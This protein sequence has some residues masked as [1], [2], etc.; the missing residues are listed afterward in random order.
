MKYLAEFES[1]KSGF[2]TTINEQETGT[3]KGFIVVFGSTDNDNLRAGAAEPLGFKENEVITGSIKGIDS[4]LKIGSSKSFENANHPGK[5]VKP[6]YDYLNVTADGKKYSIKERGALKIPFTK[7]TVLEIEGAGNGLLALMRALYFL[8]ISVT[9]NKFDYNVPFDG[10][11]FIK[12]G[13]T[14][15]KGLSL[16]VN[17]KYTGSAVIRIS[18]GYVDIMKKFV[19]ESVDLGEAPKQDNSVEQIITVADTIAD[20]IKAS[21][22]YKMKQQYKSFFSA[23]KGFRDMYDASKDYTWT[24]GSE[25]QERGSF[26]LAVAFQYCIAT[27]SYYYPMD[28]SK[29][30]KIDLEPYAKKIMDGQGSDLTKFDE[31]S[32]RTQIAAMFKQFEPKEL[33]DYP[34]FKDQLPKYWTV[35]TNAVIDRIILTM[36]ST[37]KMA[38]SPDRVG[39]KVPAKGGI[40]TGKTEFGSGKI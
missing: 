19:K 18:D 21:H 13:E 14:T 1:W 23:Y 4:M 17:G 6:G 24:K 2:A 20:A 9:E 7:D 12:I 3:G 33:K 22:F 38:M 32:I 29:I 35:I 11:L 34:E 31:Q 37:Y 15:R 36:P 8:N 10:T 30:Y 16:S 39:P 27:L 26:F 28:L 25:F 5:T 40:Q